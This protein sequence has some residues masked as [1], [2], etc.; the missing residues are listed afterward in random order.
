MTYVGICTYF[1]FFSSGVLHVGLLF[2]SFFRNFCKKI[3]RSYFYQGNLAQE[4]QVTYIF[5]LIFFPEFASLA[6]LLEKPFIYAQNEKSHG[7]I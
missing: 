3:T 6:Q 4:Q 7:S 2:F 1:S 5:T